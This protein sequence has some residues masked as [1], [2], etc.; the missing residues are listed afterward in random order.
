MSIYYYTLG[1]VK[2]IILILSYEVLLYK[3]IIISILIS[4]IKQHLTNKK[5]EFNSTVV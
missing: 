2:S 3:P 1:Y 5:C 4:Q